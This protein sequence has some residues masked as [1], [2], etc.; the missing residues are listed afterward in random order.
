MD[1]DLDCDA[2]ELLRAAGE[3]LRWRI[4]ELLRAEDLCVCHL[5]E[6]LGIPQ[7][8][9]SH[10]LGILRTAGLVETERFRYWTYY[11]LR[12]SGLAALARHLG[13]MAESAACPDRRRRPL[14]SCDEREVA[15]V[16]VFDAAQHPDV[17]NRVIDALALHWL[18]T[19]SPE[20]PLAA[21]PPNT[22]TTT[23]SLPCGKSAS[24]S[25][26]RIPSH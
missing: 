22:S 19:F 16:A 2:S 9:V 1:T 18:G 3:P 17:L 25:T 23:C 12:P 14:P 5:V 11:G 21:S 13:G 10:H 7:S 4:L 26:R 24:T 15:Q 20:T 8:S 6:A